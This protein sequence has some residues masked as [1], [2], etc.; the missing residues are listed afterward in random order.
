MEGSVVILRAGWLPT[1]Q[2][3]GLQTISMCNAFAKLGLRTTL[4]YIPSPAKNDPLR[5]YGAETQLMLKKLPRAVLPIRKNFKLEQWKA[6]PSFFHAFIWSGFVTHLVSRSKTDFYFVREPMIAWW[7]ARRGLPTVLEIHDIPKGNEGIFIHKAS[8]LDSVK[9]VLAVTE[10]LRADLVKQFKVPSEKTLTLHD[11]IEVK[12]TDGSISKVQVS[13][14]FGLPLDHPLVVYTGMIDPE[15]GLDVLARA[16][17][18]LNGIHIVIVG[19]GTQSANEWLQ[20][21]I[22]QANAKNVTVLEFQPHSDAR[23][24]QKAADVLVLPHS[25]KF[26]HSAYYTSPLKLF[27]YMAT[28]VPIVASALPAVRE[29]LRHGE[30]GWLVQPDS[31]SALAGGIVHLLERKHLA[32]AMAQRAALD[33]E[34][35]TWERRATRII[36]SMRL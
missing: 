11:G 4:Y 25:D 33:V 17:P 36:E 1:R 32:S 20:G 18:M 22:R 27:E 26:L 15:K 16:A 2:A 3:N 24:I 7:L 28:G 21:A 6:F 10:H 13:Q 19:Y 5:F 9:L 23:L 29:V 14:R 35:Y 31:P 12:T 30:N 8:R 34:D